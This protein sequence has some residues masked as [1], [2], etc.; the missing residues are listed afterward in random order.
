MTELINLSFNMH[1]YSLVSDFNNLERWEKTH[2]NGEASS[3]KEL[4]ELD[5]ESML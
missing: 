4:D 1:C 5:G 2:I 3:T